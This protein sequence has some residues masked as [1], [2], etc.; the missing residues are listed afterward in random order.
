MYCTLWAS[1]SFDILNLALRLVAQQRLVRCF[2]VVLH[3]LDKSVELRRGVGSVAIEALPLSQAGRLA[4]VS[5]VTVLR[6]S[7]S[8]DVESL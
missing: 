2:D 7:P 8:V 3:D 4:G 5:E 1:P 6:D